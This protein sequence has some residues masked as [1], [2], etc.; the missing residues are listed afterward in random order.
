MKKRVFGRDDDGRAVEEVTLESA[1]AAVS[2]LSYGCTVRDWRIDLNG[3]SLPMTLGFPT[4]EGYLRHARSHGALCGRVV[5]RIKG[6][7]F[8]LDGKT[9][10]LVANQGPNTIHG[11]PKGLG[12]VI[13]TMDVDSTAGIVQLSYASPD[14]DQG[15]PGAVDFTVTYRL[16]GPTLVCEMSGVPDQPTP[17][18]LANHSY[19]NLAGTGTVKDHLLRIDAP[20]YTPS[21][22]AQIPT[23]EILSVEGTELDFRTLREIGDTKLDNNLVLKPGRDRAKIAATAFCPRT[24]VQL[25]ILTDQPG[26]QVFDASAMTIGTTGHEGESYGPYAGFCL[27]AQHFPDSVHNPDWPSIIRTPENPYRQHLAVKI[28]RV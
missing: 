28:A 4:L 16:D 25:D 13:W 7:S 19:Y 15:F 8:E 2:I 11:G 6:A 1:D 5:N 10:P 18:N 3:S 20:S 26:L 17:I 27:E 22:E 14:G 23:G 9:W 12:K 21:D 24:D